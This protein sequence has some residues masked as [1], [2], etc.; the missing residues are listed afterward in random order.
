M[1]ASEIV[2][3]VSWAAV[4]LF[5][6]YGALRSS[7]DEADAKTRAAEKKAEE[8]LKKTEE[9]Q[10]E[11][12]LIA[13][14]TSKL[15]DSTGAMLLLKSRYGWREIVETIGLSR[16]HLQVLREVD[17]TSEI[18]LPNMKLNRYGSEEA[19]VVRR[20]KEIANPMD[21]EYGLASVF[22]EPTT[23]TLLELHNRGFVKAQSRG[24]KK[25]RRYVVSITEMG[26][27]LIGLDAKFSDRNDGLPGV[28]RAPSSEKARRAVSHVVYSSI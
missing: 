3:A 13:Q 9:A 16:L 23:D 27:K 19:R 20:A 17:G 11:M 7:R 18:V 21:Y 5:F 22:Q 8:T 6:G 4:I 15:P 24:D 28:R 26:N 10:A 12:E 1:S 14:A 25:G 2:T